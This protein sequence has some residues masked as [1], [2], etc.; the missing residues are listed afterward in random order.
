MLL[1]E[2][3]Q[4]CSTSTPDVGLTLSGLEETRLFPFDAS[5]VVP[6]QPQVL[7]DSS[8]V[9]IISLDRVRNRGDAGLAL[10]GGAATAHI[11]VHIEQTSVLGDCEGEEDALS[12]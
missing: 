9:H 4:R 5:W 7:Q 10:S 8:S 1:S 12:L 2:Y 11:D 6:Q 3:K